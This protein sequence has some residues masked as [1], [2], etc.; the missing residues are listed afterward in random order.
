[1]KAA[2]TRHALLG[3]AVM[4][5]AA[6]APATARGMAD[7]QCHRGR[8]DSGRRR[9]RHRRSR[10][11]RA[12]RQAGRPDLR[13]REPGRRRRHDRRQH[14]RQGRARRP[15]HAGLWLDRSRERA[16][17]KAVLRHGERFRAGR[18]CSGRPRWSSSRASDGYKT[19]AELVAAAKAKPGAL[20]YSTVG[21]GSAAHFGAARLEVGAGFTA[22]HIPFKGGE[23]LTEIIAG[24]IDFS[25]SPVTTAIGAIATAS[26]CRSRSCPR[27][28]SRRCP[29]CR[30]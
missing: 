15:H 11:V 16:L 2:K 3:A 14:G 27:S 22:Q 8:A 26:S 13:D 4:L 29:T 19:L 28:A 1:M 23:W 10:G 21:V 17:Y 25:V 6:L 20:N 5:C 30:R 7:A 24:R 9:Q 18:C 12:G